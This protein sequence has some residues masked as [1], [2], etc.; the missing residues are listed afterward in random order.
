MLEEKAQIVAMDEANAV[1]VETQRQT[2]CGSC[3][4]SKACGTATL[5]KVLGQKRTRVRALNKL[6]DLEIGDSVV[7]GL[8]EGAFLRGSLALYFVPLLGMFLGAGFGALFHQ[9]FSAEYTEGF[10]IVFSIG[11]FLAGMVWVKYYSRRIADNSDYQATVLRRSDPVLQ[12]IEKDPT[13]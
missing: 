5:S 12:Y 9:A 2:A 6:P 11:G 1:W 13:K 3:Q 10:R 8:Q 7:I 4:A